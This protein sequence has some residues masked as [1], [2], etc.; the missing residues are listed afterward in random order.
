MVAETEFSSGINS[1]NPSCHAVF[2]DNHGH[3][4]PYCK[5]VNAES[6]DS[7]GNFNT[8]TL[9]YLFIMKY[10]PEVDSVVLV[11]CSV[12]VPAEDLLESD[13]GSSEVLLRL[14][15]SLEAVNKLET[16]CFQVSLFWVYS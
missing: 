13:L 9:L 7:F 12:K 11:D 6:V 10:T 15:T 8:Q 4:R 5:S 14:L 3:G 2:L 16:K 1:N